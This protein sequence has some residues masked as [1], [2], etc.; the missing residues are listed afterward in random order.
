[1]V[2]V[3]VQQTMRAAMAC[4]VRGQDLVRV[5]NGAACSDNS[6]GTRSSLRK[7]V[8]F[9][10]GLLALAISFVT[11]VTSIINTIWNYLSYITAHMHPSK[12]MW[13]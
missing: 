12:G 4:E 3:L 13:R 6:T 5:G 11:S 1:M 7:A 2:Q 9:L 8:V 10:Q